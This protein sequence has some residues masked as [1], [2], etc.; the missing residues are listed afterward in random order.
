MLDFLGRL[1]P[2]IIHLPSAFIFVACAWIGVS[3]FIKKQ[4]YHSLISLLML[5]GLIGAVLSI[6]T[7]LNLSNQSAYD[8]RALTLH[9]WIAIAT[10]L[11]SGIV[12]LFLKYHFNPNLT[13][14]SAIVLLIMIVATGHLG[15]NLTHG[16]DYLIKK[17][18][19]AIQLALGYSPKDNTAN[20]TLLPQDSPQI[21]QHL[22]Q[23]LLQQHCTSCHQPSNDNGGLDLSS[24]D[25]IL[26][27]GEKG[28]VLTAG[29]PAESELFKRIAAAPGDPKYMPPIGPALSYQEVRLIEWWIKAGAP[30][31]VKLN[32]MNLSSDLVVI[33]AD[34]YGWYKQ[35]N[36]PISRLKIPVASEYLM[37]EAR[38]AG[39]II[40]RIAANSNA[41][42][43]LPS[44]NNQVVN[45]EQLKQLAPL[46]EHIVWLDLSGCQINE[47]V[48]SSIPEMPNLLKINLGKITNSEFISQKFNNLLL[49]TLSSTNVAKEGIN[50]LLLK[51]PRLQSLYLGSTTL[52]PDEVK[53]LQDTHSQVKISGNI[54]LFQPVGGS[55]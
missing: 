19:E 26:A 39:F 23:P 2:L 6:A 33:L 35:E 55:G 50:D 1:H 16:S 45:K 31:K 25:G 46:R 32:D 29:D 21:F 37:N 49:I 10:T 7:G 8:H 3:F 54:S 47:D 17:A 15:G 44:K 40:K 13:K 42:E 53:S 14:I 9:Q 52:T 27:G 36:D 4:N 51:L 18:P 41:L 20:I 24:M 34:Q 5:F 30:F 11:V 12:F 43:V 48:L 22:I 28:S 38:K